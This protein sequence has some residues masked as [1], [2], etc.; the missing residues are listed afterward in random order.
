MK[1][2]RRIE[3]LEV[4]VSDCGKY[5]DT[6]CG[7][8]LFIKEKFNKCGLYDWKLNVNYTKGKRNYRCR[9]CIEDFGMPSQEKS[10]Q[11]G[12]DVIR[13]IAEIITFML[14][15]YDDTTDRAVNER[16]KEMIRIAKEHGI[17]GCIDITE[18]IREIEGCG[19]EIPAV[20]E[21]VEE[22]LNKAMKG[23]GKLKAHLDRFPFPIPS[24]EN[25]RGGE[26]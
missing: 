23:F 11:E 25:G 3:P 2:L 10:R 13:V 15:C 26:K 19:L 24:V 20:N 1:V 18:T 21:Y 8:F 4:Q 14:D 9:P 7:D 17:E 16:F 12:R 5:C 22:N 6:A